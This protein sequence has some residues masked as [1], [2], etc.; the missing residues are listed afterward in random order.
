[1][2]T[3]KLAA[4]VVV[5]TIFAGASYW[6]TSKK[7]APQHCGAQQQYSTADLLQEYINV[8]TAQPD[9]DYTLAISFLQHRARIDGFLT[10]LIAL[11]SGL[12]AVI[13]I[14][15]GTD[16]NLPALA[17][18]HHMDVVAANRS[19]WK[20]DPF[21]ATI[22]NG[23]IYG[24]GTQDIKGVGIC[25]YQALKELKDE[26]TLFKRT[27]YLIAVP[28]EEIGGFNGACQLV[29][30]RQY[31]DLTIGYVLDEG[32]PSSSDRMLYIKITER[33]PLQVRFTISGAAAHGSQLN[34]SNVLHTLITFL[35]H[36]TRFQKNQQLKA[37]SIDPGL[38]LS[39][40]ITSCHAGQL[41]CPTKKA[42]GINMIPGSATATIDIRI[43]AQLKQAEAR[44]LLD[45]FMA[46]FPSITYE[47]VAAVDDYETPDV[48]NTNF[49]RCIEQSITKKGL[50]A[51]PLHFQAT[52]DL[53]HYLP[54][55]RAGCGLTPFT[56]H[57]NLHGIDEGVPVADLEQGKEIFKD[58]IRSFCT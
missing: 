15:P 55:I 29:Q 39:M 52:T 33:R 18:N 21:R 8:N 40:N 11:P 14:Q 30:T 19:Q 36:I 3:S 50:Q 46:P 20:N 5:V 48:T 22:N 56:C 17:L 44:A 49:Y 28:D 12:S 24:R 23:I 4:R 37:Q 35:A 58:I 32:L 42:A 13:I 53:R 16:K 51:K 6:I 45:K 1:M 26:D 25:H 54:S 7:R 9:P 2:N 41:P 27:V 38:L 47:I 43:P 10:Q 57:D 34:C 31:K